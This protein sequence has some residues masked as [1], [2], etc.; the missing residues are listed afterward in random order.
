MSI[1]NKE[2][3]IK[4]RKTGQAVWLDKKVLD[5]HLYIFGRSG[6]G[7]TVLFKRLYSQLKAEILESQEPAC[8]IT[9]AI[10]DDL[11]AENYNPETDYILNPYDERGSDF[12]IMGLVE[13]E[14][15]ITTIAAAALSAV[16][17]GSSE[18]KFWEDGGKDL[19]E[20]L[21]YMA[22][23]NKEEDPNIILDNYYLKT[24]K[25]VGIVSF[26]K[27]LQE[28]VVK[29]PRATNAL[30]RIEIVISDKTNKTAKSF[31]DFFMAATK[32]L[33]IIKQGNENE[34]IDLDQLINNPKG[35]TVFLA[36]YTDIKDDIAPYLTVFLT[37]M[38]KK[39]LAKSES[40]G[41]KKLYLFLDELGNLGKV[42]KLDELIT[43]GRSKGGHCL[44]AN[45]D[46]PRLEKIYE[47][48]ILS[49]ILESCGTNIIMNVGKDTAKY[50]EELIGKQQKKQIDTSHTTAIYSERDSK[51]VNE[52]TVI[53]E[54]ILASELS[55]FV[56]FEFVFKTIG[57][58]WIH[59]RGQFEPTIDLYEPIN[60]GYIKTDR[61]RLNAAE[62]VREQK[63]IKE[64]KRETVKEP[65]EELE[66][67]SEEEIE[68]LTP[69]D[70]D[71]EIFMEEIKESE[72][73][74]EKPSI[75]EE[76]PFQDIEAQFYSSQDLQTN[77]TESDETEDKKAVSPFE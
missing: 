19:F 18:D 71:P 50:F 67:F 20:G 35:E 29:Y 17:T 63:K 13:E 54:T 15:D 55:S 32:F 16:G 31:W 59:V 9:H 27:K 66:E 65:K 11:I 14:S 37:L 77:Q 40:D 74:P 46:T 64:Q 48:E 5:N 2:K 33:D 23:F 44:F 60:E 4:P 75:T 30:S 53:E 73:I 38:I 70:I 57:S 21:L 45:Q 61:F 68:D 62:L 43:L 6:A 12:N 51:G 49:A 3:E 24:L 1:F 69:K 39:L 76:D 10:K 58:K 42:D 8:I 28:V 56:T 25:N 52:K 26:A 72:V 7:K 36:N 41:H 34:D 47:K 22:L